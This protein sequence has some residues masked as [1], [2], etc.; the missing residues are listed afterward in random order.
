MDHV[1]E[2]FDDVRLNAL[3]L[4]SVLKSIKQHEYILINNFILKIDSRNLTKTKVRK[5]M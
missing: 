3:I 4:T 5:F 2:Q 1:A